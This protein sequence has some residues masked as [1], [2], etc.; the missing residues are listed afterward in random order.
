MSL[1]LG[2]STKLRDGIT[3]GGGWKESDSLATLRARWASQCLAYILF[4]MSISRSYSLIIS[5]YTDPDI[6][7][8]CSICAKEVDKA[9][10][11]PK[12]FRGLNSLNTNSERL[13][14]YLNTFPHHLKIPSKLTSLLVLL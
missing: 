3:S 11:T 13:W 9:R 8:F 5:L 14:A 1:C 10:R 7:L 2:S 12:E 6:F 4:K